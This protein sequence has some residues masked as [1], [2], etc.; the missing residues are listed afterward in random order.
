MYLLKIF[1]LVL[2]LASALSRYLER[3]QL[4]DAGMAV[5]HRE[6]LTRMWN[7][8]ELIKRKQSNLT[9]ADRERL[10]RRYRG[11]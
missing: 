2:G 11:H 3:K 4:I 6:Q 10:R 5:A 9:D 7:H 1:Q 8:V